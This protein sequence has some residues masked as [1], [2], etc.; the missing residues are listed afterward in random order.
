LRQRRFDGRGRLVSSGPRDGTSHGV[1]QFAE[2]SV[3]IRRRRLRGEGGAASQTFLDPAVRDVE[4]F[5]DLL[6]LTPAERAILRPWL[7]D[8]GFL[9]VDLA[10][11]SEEEV[12]ARVSDATPLVTLATLLL[13]RRPPAMLLR[14]FPE[15][16]QLFGEVK[17]QDPSGANLELLLTYVLMT[18]P[19]AA[20]E[21]LRAAI[22]RLRPLRT[23]KTMYSIADMYVAKGRRQGLA[24]G[25]N[26]G[27]AAGLR[28]ALIMLLEARFGTVS[29]PDLARIHKAGPKTLQVWLRTAVTAKSL[30]AALPRD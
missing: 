9:L 10:A 24:K 5:A 12:E 6:D 28:E 17:A 14:K 21:K 1:R 3:R 7:P 8:L 26:K 11:L 4:D 23:E 15:W 16:E 20:A 13:K 29:R 19:A 2:G 22:R 25:M 18:Q 30:R 27:R